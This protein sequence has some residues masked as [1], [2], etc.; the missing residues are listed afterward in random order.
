[1][2]RSVLAAFAFAALAPANVA[3]AQTSGPI[4]TCSKSVTLGGVSYRYEIDR[5]RLLPG[6]TWDV[7]AES[8]RLGGAYISVEMRRPF[9]TWERTAAGRALTRSDTIPQPS[10]SIIRSYRKRNDLLNFFMVKIE[11]DM[12]NYIW[13]DPLLVNR[14][15]QSGRWLLRAGG[16]SLMDVSAT[17]GVI[18]RT[19]AYVESVASLGPGSSS[20]PARTG[21]AGYQTTL[22]GLSAGPAT[23]E[24][25][26]E[27][28]LLA[29][30]TIG[31][32][33]PDFSTFDQIAAR[34]TAAY[35]RP[36]SANPSAQGCVI[37]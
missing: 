7:Q 35:A 12:P 20:P 25:Y 19:P 17:Y 30:G 14:H 21:Y 5:V 18:A 33:R 28:T 1:M 9:D 26:D 13:G 15:H 24:I 32:L 27:G 8:M 22:D 16:T 29:R 23:L 2:H 4:Y 11:L 10:L 37:Y 6:A 36:G 34:E 31:A 3:S